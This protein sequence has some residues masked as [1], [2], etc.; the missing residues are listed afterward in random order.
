MTPSGDA[1]NLVDMTIAMLAN[2]E[3]P[4]IEQVRALMTRLRAIVSVTEDDFEAAVAHVESRHVLSMPNGVM[5]AEPKFE[6]WLLQRRSD[7]DPY[8]WNRYRRYLLHDQG[9]GPAV[10]NQLD[11]TVDDLLEYAGDPQQVGPWKR[12]GLVVGDVQSGKTATYTALCN[13]AADA[14]YRLIILL[15]GTLNGLRFQTQERLDEG[16]VG[17]DSAEHTLH[18]GQVH[19]AK[20]VGVGKYGKP[21][22]VLAFTTKLGDFD[23]R[24]AKVGTP[25]DGLKAPALLVIKKNKTILENLHTWLRTLNTSQD[26]KIA[27]PLLLIDDEAD[28]AT[29]NT[30][31]EN[32]PRAINK[33]IRKLLELFSRSSYVGFTATPFANVF[34]APDSSADMLGNDLFPRDYIYSLE[35]PSNYVGPVRVF[36]EEQDQFLRVIDDADPIFP[37]KHKTDLHVSELPESLLEALRSFVV[38]NAIRDLRGEGPTHRSMLVN[39][40]WANNVQ[41]QVAAL[42]KGHLTRLIDAVQAFGALEPELARTQSRELAA[43]EDLWR[44]EYRGAG[45]SWCD[46]QNALFGAIKAVVVNAVNMSSPTSRLNYDEHKSTGLRVIA[47]GGNALSRGLTLYGL[48]TSYMFR[49]SQAYDTLLQMGRW[50]GYRPGYEDLCRIW[51]TRSSSRYYS[52][53]TL[54][55]QELRA[56]LRHMRD[57]GSTPSHFGLKVRAHTDSLIV[58]ARAK[59]KTATPVSEGSVSLSQRRLEA[60]QL[61][62]TETLLRSNDAAIATFLSIVAQEGTPGSGNS[63]RVSKLWTTVPK[64]LVA[65]LLRSFRVHPASSIFQPQRIATFLE[66]VSIE[67]LNAWDVGI[68]SGDRNRTPIDYHGFSVYT[69]KRVA[70][71]DVSFSDL[72]EIKKRR[73]SVQNDDSIGMNRDDMALAEQESDRQRAEGQKPYS[74]FHYRGKRRRPLL[75]IYVV[76][77]DGSAAGSYVPPVNPFPAISVSFPRYADDVPSRQVLYQANQ[78]WQQMSNALQ[79]EIDEDDLEDISL[80]G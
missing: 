53:I 1:K 24:V 16:F 9:W 12:R 67:E 78:V 76:D 41:G 8:F 50:F 48:S 37:L 51:M 6:K 27:A 46:V 79:A 3:R 65:Q 10:V 68:V 80:A 21:R 28:A 47:V 54:A 44:R 20:A 26:G 43:L 11:Q 64:R 49:N 30:G 32:D 42:L 69:S 70:E 38:A 77:A 14:G 13:K 33:G 52:H 60:T 5:V 55:T 57:A 45:F 4:T 23:A 25:L 40:S 15:A 34:I 71:R 56:E 18:K 36:E 19:I 35:P 73:L 39:V 62:T 74:D 29:V 66:D 63:G 7:I 17:R 2:D 75:L 59:M 31:P 72:F 58:T 61:P 22:P